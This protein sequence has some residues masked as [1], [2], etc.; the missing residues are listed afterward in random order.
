M[1]RNM[2]SLR[3]VLLV[4]LGL[5]LVSCGNPVD[6]KAE[7]TTLHRGLSIDPESVD[8]HKS[9]SVQAA[10]VLR[11]IGEGLLSY[12]A[13]GELVGGV[14]KEW[15]VA[16]DGLTYTFLLRDDARWSNGDPVTAEDFAFSFRRLVDPDTAAFYAEMLGSI[17][18]V[19]TIIA[20][21]KA[22][23]DLGVVAVDERTLVI[24]L[25][26]PTPYLLSLLTSPS[27][28]PVH[29]DSIAQHGDA[30]TRPGNLLSNGAY[31][32]DAWE[33]GS[34]LVLSRNEYYWNNDETAI[35][36]VNHHVLTQ[37]MT[38]LN[39]YRAGEIH[40]T[41][42]VPPDSI[43]QIRAERP[44]ELHIAPYLGVYYYGFNL[45]RPPFKDNPQLRAALSMAVD[46]DV[47]VEQITGRGEAP[48]YSWVPPGVNNYE[49]RRLAYADMS[50]DERN[51]HARRLVK[52]AGYGPDN[53]LQIELRYNTSDT[54]QRMALAIQSMWKDALGV[55]TTIINEEFQVLLANTQAREITQVFRSSWIGD[56]NDAHT[57]LSIMESDNPANQPAYA[58]E[59]FDSLMQ[60]AAQ[61]VD[62][63]RRRLWLEEA[64]R[65]LLADHPGIPLYFY[66][67]KHLVSPDVVGWGDNVLD[68]H[69]S[70]H[71]SLAPAG[72]TP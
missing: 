3:L 51:A 54:Q 49:P 36:A 31:K 10:E 1:L 55:E 6:P 65:V 21:E 14:A 15:T 48:A 20:G 72:A 56:Y 18:N 40:I 19:R 5:T 25:D 67:S 39:R 41:G 43:Q 30:F 38:E 46:R 22:P 12:S 35:D 33:P 64:E 59:E 17:V 62:L 60:R 23:Q 28:F 57:F 70:Q 71:L 50:Q 9:R 66:V 52:E 61:Q 68:Y 13:S 32:L 16:E 29:P 8:P 37:E 27:T 47:L 34:V 7:V 42:S 4:A 26:Q 53:P 44:A 2:I 69:Y 58:S 45:T 24:T 11:D 63:D